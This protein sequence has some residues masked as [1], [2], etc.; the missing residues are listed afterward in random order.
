MSNIGLLVC[1]CVFYA[2]ILVRLYH[3]F[4]FCATTWRWNSC[5][6]LEL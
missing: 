1:T 6:Y 3:F 2:Y 4:L 5:M